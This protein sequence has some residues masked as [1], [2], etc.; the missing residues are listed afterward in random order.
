M[1]IR[2]NIK[3]S[4]KIYEVF[5]I[6]DGSIG[7]NYSKLELLKFAEEFVSFSKRKNTNNSLYGKHGNYSQ[8]YLTLNLSTAFA[9]YQH[10]LL[11]YEARNNL[12]EFEDERHGQ[13][14]DYFNNINLS[15]GSILDG[16]VSA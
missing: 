2:K 1:E 11:K 9:K 8:N 7:Q 3:V 5:S 16:M 12:I 10:K 15:S 6:L 13:K 4:D 14:I